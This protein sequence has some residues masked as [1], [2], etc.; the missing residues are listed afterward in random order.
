MHMLP[1]HMSATGNRNRSL[2]FS[3]KCALFSLV[4]TLTKLRLE[5][6]RRALADKENQYL[7]SRDDMWQSRVHELHLRS[8]EKE[9]QQLDTE[10]QRVMETD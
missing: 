9:R 6:R 2:F 8:F 10:M 1:S 7:R 3:P 4:S 5:E